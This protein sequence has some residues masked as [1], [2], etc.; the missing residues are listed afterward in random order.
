MSTSRPVVLLT[1]FGPFP[2]V[3]ANASAVLVPRIAEL[4]RRALPGITVIEQILPTEWAASLALIDELAGRHRPEVAIH[5]GV[6]SRAEGFEIETRARNVCTQSADASG[7]LPDGPCVSPGGMEALPA[8]L[9]ASLIVERLR[10]R[11]LPARISRDAG[12][13]L[14]NA[15]LYRSL[16]NSRAYGTPGRSG[17]IHLPSD[18]V[19]ERRPWSEPPANRRLDWDG[20]IA[21]GVEILGAALGRPLVTSLRPVLGRPL[22][23]V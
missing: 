7:A 16:E 9:P 1:G 3:A 14:C 6:S 18:L 21:G 4:A 12:G 8:S 20:V 19:S 23:Q 10:R 5:F 15:V 13:Y 17:F 11:R 2:T 22:R